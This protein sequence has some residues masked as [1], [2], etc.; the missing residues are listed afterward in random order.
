[1]QQVSG[2]EESAAMAAVMNAGRKKHYGGIRT[3]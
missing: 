1:M 3:D 2:A